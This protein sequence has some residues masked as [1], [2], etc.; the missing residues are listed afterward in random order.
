MCYVDLEPCEVWDE[1]ERKACKSHKCNCCGGAIRPGEMYLVHFSVFEGLPN[2]E[3]MCGPCRDDRKEFAD[4]HDGTLC[5]PHHL[6][7]MVSGCIGEGF[8][9]G[10]D[11]KWKAML[12]R[13]DDRGNRT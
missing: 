8:D 11:E 12:A 1:R 3:K 13:I 4:A 6:W 5:Q 7:E 9:E 2:S 10:D